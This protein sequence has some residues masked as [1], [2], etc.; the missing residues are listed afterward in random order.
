MSRIKVVVDHAGHSPPQELLKDTLVSL[1]VESETS[2]NNKSLIV[3][4]RTTG[5]LDVEVDGHIRHFFG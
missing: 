2:L 4:V 5:A 3:F 1:E